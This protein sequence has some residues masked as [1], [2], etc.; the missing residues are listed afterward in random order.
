MTRLTTHERIDKFSF[1]ILAGFLF[2]L[3]LYSKQF[4]YLNLKIAG[5][6]I[7]ISEVVL[8]WVVFLRCTRLPAFFRAPR[9]AL[10]FFFLYLAWGFT[11]L[12]ISFAAGIPA[13][14]GLQDTLKQTSIFYLAIWLVVPLLFSLE[15]NRKLLLAALFGA[16]AAQ[17]LGWIGF[18]VMGVYGKVFS[19]LIGFPVGNEVL[20]PLYPLVY[21]LVRQP[22][23][24]IYS[25]SFGQLWLTQFL[26]Y[27]KRTWVFSVV[28]FSLPVVIYCLRGRSTEKT[29]RLLQP[30][31]FGVLIAAAGVLYVSQRE[32][33]WLYH[34]EE[35]RSVAQRAQMPAV[36]RGALSLLDR[37]FPYTDPLETRVSLSQ[38][39]FKGDLLVQENRTMSF[40]AFRIHLWRQAWAGFLAK[41]WFGQGFG[42][43]IVQ[44]QLNGLPAVVDGR[45]ISGPHNSFLTVMNRLGLVGIFLLVGLVGAVIWRAWPLR[46]TTFGWMMVAALLNVHF[47]CLFNVC[48]ENPQGGVWYWLFLGMAL[49][50]FLAKA[51][52]KE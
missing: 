16:G 5:F 3:G 4:A 35:T 33:P 24:E 50:A 34:A 20:L 37:V 13:D 45:W 19:R 36:A 31:L 49:Q 48:L 32:E 40:M 30:L 14:V 15:Q 22:W 12:A 46:L 17:L 27:M 42:T 11:R 2:L 28:V 41:P 8:A 47:F 26:I 9:A 18:L 10:A 7:Y 38:V 51:E 23:A 43:R 21:L 6:P 29:K 44:T 39:I 25:L 1:S 52:A